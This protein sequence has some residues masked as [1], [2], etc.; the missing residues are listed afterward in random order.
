MN[1]AGVILL[2]MFPG[3]LPALKGKEK[4]IRIFAYSWCAL[5]GVSRIM[6]GAHFASDVA[7]GIMLSFLLFELTGM[8]VSRIRLK[9]HRMEG[10]N[11]RY[12]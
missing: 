6:M 10:F 3:F 1:S 4:A 11:E 8:A 12:Y 7:V 2:L 5:V 9:K